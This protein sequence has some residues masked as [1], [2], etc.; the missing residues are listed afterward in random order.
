MIPGWGDG[1]R[2]TTQEPLTPPVVS[3]NER[4]PSP[5]PLILHPKTDHLVVLPVVLEIPAQG[6]LEPRKTHGY[7]KSRRRAWTASD[8]RLF[9]DAELGWVVLFRW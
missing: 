6:R 7:R 9:A 1:F 3:S 8:A 4:D 2:P 5:R